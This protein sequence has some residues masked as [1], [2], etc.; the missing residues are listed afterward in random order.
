M[1]GHF[2]L[3][4]TVVAV[5][6][7]AN[8]LAI[9]TAG[10]KSSGSNP[11]LAAVSGIISGNV[12]KVGFRAL[13]QKQAIA[14]NLAGATAN[15][16]DQ[17]VRFTLQGDKKRIDKAL[18]IIGGG[19][20]KSSDVKV[21]LSPAEVDPGLHTFTI[22]GW[23]SKTRNINTPYDLVFTLRPDNSTIKKQAAKAVWLGICDLAVKGQD[24]GKCEKDDE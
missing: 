18:A 10:A 6:A 3:N 20:K 2:L 8:L 4:R 19:T 24:V 17:T 12:Q 13:I 14:Y 11:K 7:V 22:V 9:A 5:V 21:S 16:D 15:N 1:R 23:T